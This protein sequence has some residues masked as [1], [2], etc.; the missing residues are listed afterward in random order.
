M[1][2]SIYRL[3]M[4]SDILKHLG[5]RAQRYPPDGWNTGGTRQVEHLITLGFLVIH[6]PRGE[7]AEAPRGE[8]FSEGYETPDGRGRRVFI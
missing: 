1:T 3:S 4:M 6:H 7:Y 2:Q 5:M 8:L